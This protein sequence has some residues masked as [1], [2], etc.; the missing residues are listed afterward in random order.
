MVVHDSRRLERWHGVLLVLA[1]SFLMVVAYSGKPGLLVIFGGAGILLSAAA[2]GAVHERLRAASSS[3]VHIEADL[4]SES[5]V[6]GL[7]KEP[8]RS[9]V[10]GKEPK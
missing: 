6:T 10:M 1:F 2:L 5:G 7:I 9:A 4:E 3:C 8:S